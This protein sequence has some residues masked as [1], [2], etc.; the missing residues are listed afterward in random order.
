M[1]GA[2]I[3]D[4][5]GSKYE[6]NSIKTKDFPF[7]AR[8]CEFTDDTVMTVAVARALLMCLEDGRAFKPELVRQMQT[9]GRRY[10]NAGYGGRFLCW[11]YRKHPEPYH[12]YGNGSAMRVSPCGLMAVTLEEATGLARASAEVTHDHPAGIAGAEAAAAAVFLAKTGESKE[13]IRDYIRAHYYPLDRTLDDIRPKYRFDVTC[14]GSVPQSIQA[15]LEADSYEDTVRN[16]ISLGGDSDTQAAIAGAIA[17][18]YYR[19][20]RGRSGVE[21]G[22]KPERRWPETCDGLIRDYG[23]DGM[24]PGDFVETIERFDVAWTQRAGT[25]AQ[26]GSCTPVTLE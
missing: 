11:L 21:T 10:P 1:Y 4:I 22:K 16:A 19:L 5:A 18:S 14:Q 9:L 24:L 15:F 23:I 25:F 6:F 13:R 2:I 17:W 26:T 12:S 20:G 7:I 3:G 8:G